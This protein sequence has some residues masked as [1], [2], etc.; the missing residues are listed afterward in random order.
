MRPRSRDTA[1]PPSLNSS[2]QPHAPDTTTLPRLLIFKLSAVSRR[3]PSPRPLIPKPQC[4]VQLPF[5]TSPPLISKPPVLS[6]SVPSPL[7]LPI[8]PSS[9]NSLPS[10]RPLIP[11]PHALSRRHPSSSTVPLSSP[12]LVPSYQIPLTV[13]PPSLTLSMSSR[14]PTQPHI[15]PHFV[16]LS[17]NPPA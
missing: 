6:Y 7:L 11:K 8:S 13:L 10:S 5:L 1:P 9:L 14:S 12:H 17:S 2:P 3:H 4:T 15:F 16:F